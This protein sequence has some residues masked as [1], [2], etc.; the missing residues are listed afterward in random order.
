MKKYVTRERNDRFA[1]RMN[2]AWFVN[3]LIES[4]SNKI[5]NPIHKERLIKDL[6]H[7]VDDRINLFLEG[8]L[9]GY[10]HKYDDD[11]VEE[12]IIRSVYDAYENMVINPPALFTILHDDMRREMLAL[13]WDIDHFIDTISEWIADIDGLLDQ[14]E[15]LDKTSETM[16]L[17]T[18]NY[19]N[20]MIKECT[21]LT[22][23]EQ[24]EMIRDL[25]IQNTLK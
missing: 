25:R 2:H 20:K 12:F 3:G 1:Q 6:E 17:I 4:Y 10:I 18:Q 22:K 19:V 21:G 11:A 23:Q 14:F 8:P 5:T 13:K 9:S 7:I 15:Y 16:R 24:N